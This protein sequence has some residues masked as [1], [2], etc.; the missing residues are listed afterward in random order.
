MRIAKDLIHFMNCIDI[1]QS[2]IQDNLALLAL[3]IVQLLPAF[4]LVGVAVAQMALT[5]Q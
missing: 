5:E 1:A 2:S 4:V 3:L